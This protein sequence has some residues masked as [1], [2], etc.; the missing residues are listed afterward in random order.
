MSK[1]F[2]CKSKLEYLDNLTET[3]EILLCSKCKIEYLYD[4]KTK[5]L[6]EQKES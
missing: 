6:F 2:H 4:T 3:E 1:C 5:E